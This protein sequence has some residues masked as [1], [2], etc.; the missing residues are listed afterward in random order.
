M[1]AIIIDLD[2]S[3]NHKLY[4]LYFAIFSHTSTELGNNKTLIQY[5]SCFSLF[6]LFSI[7]NYNISFQFHYS[8]DI[9]VNF[10]CV[11]DC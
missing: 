2:S 7:I 8:P 3:W 11:R 1:V 6:Y 5:F 10:N 9:E 4:F